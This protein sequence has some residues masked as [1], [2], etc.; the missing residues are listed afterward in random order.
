MHT[1]VKVTLSELS[2]FN[3]GARAPTEPRIMNKEHDDKGP[4]SKQLP[5]AQRSRARGGPGNGQEG[6]LASE[7]PLICQVGPR[8]KTEASGQ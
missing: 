2:S 6:G 8:V 5:A 1:L 3:N 7:P 4:K